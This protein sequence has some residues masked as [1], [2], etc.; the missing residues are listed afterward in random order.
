LKV[1][2]IDEAGRGAVIG[3]MVVAGILIDQSKIE[4]L[5]KVKVKD[6]KKLSPGARVELSKIIKEIAEKVEIIV[7][8]AATVDRS[9]RKKRSSGLNELEARIFAKI[10]DSLKPDAAYI[11]LPS[12]RY[13]EFRRLIENLTQH[14]C[15]LILEHKADEKYPVVSAASI[16][17]KCERDRLI[18][19]LKAKLG[20]FGSGYPS[21]PKTR[22][23]LL[24]M[25]KTGAIKNEHVR[26]SW[27]TL[28]KVA[29][30]KLDEFSHG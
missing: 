18:E 16:I 5:I 30:R 7:L 13:D 8:D 28:S 22:S 27:K 29:Q 11:D 12:T 9:T 14:R 25:M 4:E 10:I 24:E 17:A 2:G 20:D 23:F 15:S 19:E 6:S 21:D 1:C 26:S 3:P